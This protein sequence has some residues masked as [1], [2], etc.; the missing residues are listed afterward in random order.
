MHSDGYRGY[1]PLNT[2]K[3]VS[4]N[5]WIVDGPEIGYGFLGLQV[6]C[7][8]RMT[9]VRLAE[10]S[11]WLHSPTKLTPPLAEEVGA[12][13]PIRYI[14]AP[15]TLHYIFVQDWKAYF[16]NA[17][18]FA[19][20]ALKQFAKCDVPEYIDL[21]NHGAHAWADEIKQIIVTSR[22]FTEACFFHVPTRT[23][24]LTDLIG[25]FELNRVR[26]PFVRFF[27]RTGGC[28]HPHGTTPLDV[29]VGLLAHRKSVG[30]AVRR[31]ID[32]A[33]ERIILAHG[34]W[35]RDNAIEELKRAFRWAL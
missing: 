11:I 15:N 34:Q 33:P 7:P 2:L 31:M 19:V 21:D 4:T 3:P 25:S 1:A 32:W 8:T 27:L 12:L 26:S 6:P 35:Y 17:Q 9:V 20:P 30:L 29:R 22:S 14:I 28:V 18:V 16:P 10:G 23:L 24:V 5:V 13:G